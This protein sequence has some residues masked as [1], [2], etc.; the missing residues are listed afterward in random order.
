MREEEERDIRR[1][2]ICKLRMH[3]VLNT[4]NGIRF[5]MKTDMQK[6]DRALYD[7]GRF[8]QGIM[9]IVLYN[10]PIP[11]EEELRLV[12]SYLKLE[13]LHKDFLTVEIVKPNLNRYI[14]PGGIYTKA[15]QMVK[16]DI[17]DCREKRTFLCTWDELE[18]AM[19]LQIAET[20]N[21]RLIATLREVDDG[22][23]DNH[24]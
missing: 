4:M 12:E 8:L 14:L 17:C 19:V 24:G 6:A 13:C 7:L 9:T 11:L 20:G 23:K 2:V 5:L 10:Q 21:R 22:V 16:Q 15:E 3:Y 18:S 1:N